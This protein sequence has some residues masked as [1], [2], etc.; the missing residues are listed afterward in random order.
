MRPRSLA[1]GASILGVAL[2]LGWILSL[3]TTRVKNWFVMTDELY[4]ERLA[5]SVAQTGSLL[6]RIHGEIVSNVNQLY[7]ILI[8]TVYGDGDVAASLESVHRLN[9]FLIASTAI[10]VFLLAR[11]QGIGVF[12]ALWAG[13][14]SVAVPWIVLSSFLL[15]ENVAYPMFCWAVLAVTY[16]VER[17]HWTAD[18]L[19][20]GA[21]GAAVVARTQFVVLIGVLLVAVVVEAIVET[22]WRSAARDLWRSRRPFVVLYGTF[23]LVVLAAIVAGKGSSLLGSYSVTAEKVRID[24]DLVQLL[25]EHVAALALGLAIL[26]FLVGVAWL[27]DRIRPSASPRERAFALVG[28]TSL[29]LVLVQVASFNQR[30]GAGLVKDRYL[31]YVVPVV[32]LGL[33]AAVSDRRWPRW[34]ALTIPAAAAAVGFL[35]LPVTPYEKLNVDSI[36]AILNRELLE[37]STTTRWAHVLLVLAVVV[38]LQALLFARAFLPWRPVAVTVAVLASIAL[39]LE[40]VYAF[41][42]LFAVNGTNGLPVTLDQGGVFGWVD[43]LVGSDGRVTAV[44][45]PVGG[46]DWWSGQG[47]WWDLE[48]WNESAVETMADM[49]LRGAEPWPD[50]FDPDTGEARETPDSRYALFYGYDSRFRLAGIQHHFER[51]AYIVEPERP[52]RADWITRGIWPDGFTRPHAPAT[53]SVYAKPGQ[54]TALRRFLTIEA[55]NPDSVEPRPVSITSGQGD[56]SGTI[57]PQQSLRRQLRLCVPPGGRATVRIATPGVSGIYRDPTV[58]PPTGAADR[59]VGIQLRTVALADETEPLDR[60]PA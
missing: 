60:C 38:A 58:G 2:A 11:R 7:P 5:V 21:I 36:V 57:A 53:I 16:A 34:W 10:P 9:A 47:Y 3:A 23:L 20:L 50:L 43:R 29:V 19:A 49:S 59:P 17:K 4:Y 37:L 45:Y 41:D 55:S 15:T 35:S 48:F 12:L 26:P 14:L 6:P 27:I 40:A 28:V 44:K 51:D 33:A 18:L 24:F 22:S 39:P 13:A 46:P 32:L 8:S 25:F 31:F 42:R 52:W 1:D 54:R 56:W 30:F